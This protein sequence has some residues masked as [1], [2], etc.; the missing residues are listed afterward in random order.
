[1]ISLVG[2]SG[3]VAALA[4]LAGCALPSSARV[5]YH[6]AERTVDASLPSGVI[7]H[8]ASVAPVAR[9]EWEGHGVFEI[10]EGQT[11]HGLALEPAVGVEGDKLEV[12]FVAP[13]GVSPSSYS[14]PIGWCA[15]GLTYVDGSHKQISVASSRLKD[16]GLVAFRLTWDAGKNGW[17]E[18]N[19]T[20]KTSAEHSGG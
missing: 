4:V 2:R 14:P 13:S 11:D 10:D 12:R 6:Q 1:M 18:A 16:D 7:V 15:D 8:F 20:A 19:K 17:V 9:I 5:V 3:I